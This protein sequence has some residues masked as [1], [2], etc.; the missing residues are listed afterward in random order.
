MYMNREIMK[1]MS[2]DFK[3]VTDIIPKE[4]ISTI[5]IRKKK[6]LLWLH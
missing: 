4:N 6:T 1:I 5:K 2:L 3:K